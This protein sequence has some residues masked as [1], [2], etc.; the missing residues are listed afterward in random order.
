V[1]S[2]EKR[3]GGGVPGGGSGRKVGGAAGVGVFVEGGGGGGAGVVGAG[4]VGS[5]P[6]NYPHNS[7]SKREIYEQRL[8]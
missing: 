2:G 1:S 5:L 3:E 8:L 7:G 4:G 6:H